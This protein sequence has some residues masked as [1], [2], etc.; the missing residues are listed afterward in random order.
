MSASAPGGRP[1]ASRPAAES[2]R[3][4]YTEALEEVELRQPL[5]TSPAAT[6]LC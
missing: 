5:L 4:S 2:S 6:V 3:H 1:T